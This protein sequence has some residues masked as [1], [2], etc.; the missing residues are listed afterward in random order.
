MKPERP[1]NALYRLF[2]HKTLYT[3]TLQTEDHRREAVQEFLSVSRPD[4]SPQALQCLAESVPPLLP[5]LHRKWIGMFVDRLFETVPE[6]QIAL[7]CDG[8][9]DNNAALALAYIMFLE[10]ERMEKQMAADLANC[11]LGNGSGEGAAD[12][13]A[14]LCARLARADEEIQKAHIAKAARYAGRDPETPTQ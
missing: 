11:E 5:D 4:L 9:E 13:V 8:S 14:N 2:I 6:N 10:S 7:L 3:R 1:E 12:M